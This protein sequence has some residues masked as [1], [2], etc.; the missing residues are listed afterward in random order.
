[1]GFHYED[2]SKSTVLHNY[3]AAH[4][5]HCARSRIRTQDRS[6]NN[7]A[8]KPMSHHIFMSHHHIFI[9][10]SN[11]KTGVHFPSLRLPT[12][13]TL[14]STPSFPPSSFPLWRVDI[15]GLY[16]PWGMRI[17]LSL[18]PLFA[19]LEN[20]WVFV[21][22]QLLEIGKKVGSSAWRNPPLLLTKPLPDFYLD[23]W[24]YQH[25]VCDA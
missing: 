11:L 19:L 6:F 16:S 8:C 5:D 24:N 23:G 2:N 25:F 15:I 14:P 10:N 7:L 9:F 18:F 17:N 3:P 13:P 22:V 20:N 4:Q 12:P 21:P 1:M